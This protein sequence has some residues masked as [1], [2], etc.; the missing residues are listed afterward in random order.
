MKNMSLII[1]DLAESNA[2]WHYGAG[3]VVGVTDEST[4][5]AFNRA[6]L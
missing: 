1:F 3:A 5:A 4:T 6:L 2:T